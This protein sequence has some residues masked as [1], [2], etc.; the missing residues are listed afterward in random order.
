MTSEN[1]YNCVCDI[2]YAGNPYILDGCLN[3]KGNMLSSSID[4]NT[5][6]ATYVFWALE[7]EYMIAC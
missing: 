1:G 2:G 5:T 3:D 4:Q 6:F 7:L